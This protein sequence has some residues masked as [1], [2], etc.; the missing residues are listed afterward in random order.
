M[1]T[2]TAFETDSNR[3][4]PLGQPPRSACITAAGAAS[5]VPSLR[6]GGWGHKFVYQKWPD[7]VFPFVNFVFSNDGHFGLGC[8]QPTVV[9]RSNLSLRHPT[10]QRSAQN[11]QCPVPRPRR[12]RSANELQLREGHEG[13]RVGLRCAEEHAVEGVRRVVGE[14]QLRAAAAAPEGHVAG[15][16]VG[17]RGAVRGSQKFPRGRICCLKRGPG[18]RRGWA[19]G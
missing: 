12:T 17:P 3:P 7:Q 5:E 2:S 18:P 13:G 8:C 4:Q 14:R 19:R 10:Q 15:A 16:D 6:P 1:P 9:S 11:P